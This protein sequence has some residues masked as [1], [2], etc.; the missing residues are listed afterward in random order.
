MHE[1]TDFAR[2]GN[3]GGVRHYAFGGCSRLTRR[4]VLPFAKAV[5]SAGGADVDYHALIHGGVLGE[6]ELTQLCARLSDEVVLTRGA[7]GRVWGMFSARSPMESAVY[8]M[9]LRG[10]LG[11]NARADRWAA[12]QGG[13]LES[14]DMTDKVEDMLGVVGDAPATQYRGEEVMLGARAA[15]YHAAVCAGEC[16]EYMIAEAICLWNIRAFCQF[17]CLNITVGL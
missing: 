1:K 4:A 16:A 17:I 2:G 9:R 3:C 5:E 11:M 8:E 7:D 10:A 13:R 12:A 15:R 14:D 6:Y